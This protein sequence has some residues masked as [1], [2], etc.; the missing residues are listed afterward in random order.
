VT[1]SWRKLAVPAL[2][3]AGLAAAGWLGTRYGLDL[4]AETSVA[5][6]LPDAVA[7]PL[8]PGQKVTFIELGSDGCKPCEAMKPVMRALR[9]RHP[10]QVQVV[11]HDVRKD[12]SQAGRYRIRLIPTQV[13]L[14]PDGT[15][16]FRHEGYL[17]ESRV[18][19]VLR[20]MGVNRQ[21]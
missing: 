9:D 21:G 14:L 8:K 10:E 5:V 16:F 18:M 6:L 1:R 19:E 3:L 20:R 4:A 17:P 13:F 7:A 15:E 11:F 2:F 12:P